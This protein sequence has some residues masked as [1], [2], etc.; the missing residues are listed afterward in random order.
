MVFGKIWSG[1]EIFARLQRARRVREISRGC[2]L[3]RWP[4]ATFSRASGACETR[5]EMSKLHTPARLPRW[6]PRG[7]GPR[8]APGSVLSDDYSNL[9]FFQPTEF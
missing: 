2:A 3:R 8:S 7:W 6:G 5:V 9:L 1:R 4:L